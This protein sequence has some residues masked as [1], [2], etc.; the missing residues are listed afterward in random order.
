MPL[1][2]QNGKIYCIRSYQTDDIYIGSTTRPLSERKSGHVR[3]YARW[4]N[5]HKDYTSSFELLKYDDHYIELVEYFPCNSKEELHKREGE[6][7]RETENCVNK[8]IAGRNAKEWYQENKEIIKNKVKIY[9][10]ENKEKIKQRSQL[11]YAKNKEQ[12]NEKRRDFYS[13]NKEPFSITA[14]KYYQENKEIIK[15][16]SKENYEKNKEKLYEKYKCECGSTLTKGGQRRH[17][18]TKSHIKWL[19]AQEDIIE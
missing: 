17:E 2:Y 19:E 4:Q 13:E 10:R 8:L 12:I 1:N 7:T 16:K 9:R 5:G 11:Y 6:I 14:K 15:Q 3:K 18:K